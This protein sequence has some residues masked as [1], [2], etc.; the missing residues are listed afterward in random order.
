MNNEATY[1]QFGCAWSAPHGWRN[2]DASPTLRFERIPVIGKLYTKNDKRF[3]LNVAYGDITKGLPI[4]GASCDA[5]Y[6]SH[7]LEHLSLDDCRVALRN[8][9]KILKP[10]G[11]FRFVLPDLEYLI[12]LYTEAVQ[13][14]APTPG[15]DFMRATGL[16]L[17]KRAYGIK[18]LVYSIL[19]NSQH[20]WMW[21]YQSLVHELEAVGFVNIKRV[22][23]GDS[24]IHQ[25]KE[26]E[27]ISRW[28][29]C[30]GIECAKQS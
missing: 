24:T 18:G 7:V 21:D 4:I 9:Y 30:L 14:R 28:E 12:R 17:E 8:T 10:G 29:N 3:P 6:C 26:V 5:V 27:N 16:G 25:F 1:V 15:L 13:N 23:F 22:Q 11:V 19:G 20:L 2:F